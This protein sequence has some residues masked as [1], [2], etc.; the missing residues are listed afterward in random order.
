MVRV[1]PGPGKDSGPGLA[2]PKYLS[3]D[4]K[5]GAGWQAIDSTIWRNASSAPNGTRHCHCR[6]PRRPY[7]RG[8]LSM[9]SSGYQKLSMV[10]R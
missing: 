9:A 5:L 2:S 6:N 10:R 8:Q 1:Q 3:T 4:T 7:M